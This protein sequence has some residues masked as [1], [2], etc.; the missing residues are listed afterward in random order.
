MNENQ[1]FD[2]TENKVALEQSA[3]AMPEAT[4]TKKIFNKRS[5]REYVARDVDKQKDKANVG[6][7]TIKSKPRKQGQGY[8][9]V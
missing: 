6:D 4:I 8:H 2:A 7:A 3:S 9:Q 5:R 1:Q